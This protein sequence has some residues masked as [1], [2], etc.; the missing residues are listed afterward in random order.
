MG[1]KGICRGLLVLS[2][3]WLLALSRMGLILTMR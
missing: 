3:R 1:R 2:M